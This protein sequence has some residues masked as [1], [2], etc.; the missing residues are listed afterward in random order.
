MSIERGNAFQRLL[1]NFITH[2][3]K[4]LLHTFCELFYIL[5]FEINSID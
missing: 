1:F 5:I 2:I 4:W 3:S